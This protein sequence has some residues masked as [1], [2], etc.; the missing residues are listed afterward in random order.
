MN[1]NIMSRSA[2]NLDIFAKVGGK[3]AFAAGIVCIVT[4]FLTLIFGSKMFAGGVTALDLDFIKFHLKDSTYVNGQ[5]LKLYVCAAS[6]G[7]SILCLLLS[8]IFKLFREILSPMKAGRPFEKGISKHLK[9]V[10]WAVLIGGFLS[11]LV[12]VAARILLIK[13]Y[14]LHELFASAVIAKTEFV[15]TMNFDFVLLA[16]VI[17]LLSYVFTYGQALQQDSDETL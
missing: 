3:L 1:H 2:K 8:Y 11:E 9:K 5:F 14:S 6:F 7:G 4:A 16:C 13:A 10:G 12:G 17:F 15:L